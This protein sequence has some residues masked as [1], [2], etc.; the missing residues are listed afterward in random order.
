MYFS[1][2][3]ESR[4]GDRKGPS[5]NFGISYLS[6]TKTSLSF[7][8]LKLAGLI[9]YTCSPLGR[10]GALGSAFRHGLP[11]SPLQNSGAEDARVQWV[12]NISVHQSHLEGSLKQAT[13]PRLQSF[14]FRRSGVEPE[15][16]HFNSLVVMLMLLAWEPHFENHCSH[17]ITSF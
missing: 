12:S 15:N 1:G 14:R 5:K 8:F 3:I 11:M 13:E 7:E 6:E 4:L 9:C 16:W 2:A 17:P 10:P